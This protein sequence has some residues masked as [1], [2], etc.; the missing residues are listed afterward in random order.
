MSFAA[1]LTLNNWREQ[2]MPKLLADLTLNNWREQDMVELLSSLPLDLDTMRPLILRVMCQW[3]QMSAQ[4]L[5]QHGIDVKVIA[6]KQALVM[7]KLAPELFELIVRSHY[8]NWNLFAEWVHVAKMSA[9][10]VSTQIIPRHVPLDDEIIGHHGLTIVRTQN[11]RNVLSSPDWSAEN[12]NTIWA[13]LH[14]HV[15]PSQ[16]LE[17]QNVP[18]VLMAFDDL[19]YFDLS[20]WLRSPHP[21]QEMPLELLEPKYFNEWFYTVPDFFRFSGCSLEFC[22]KFAE[23]VGW[24]TDLCPD[25]VT[26]HLQNMCKYQY[27]SEDFVICFRHLNL[28][29]MASEYVSFSR[30]IL[31]FWKQLDLETLFDA[32]DGVN[33][34][35]IE[36]LYCPQDMMQNEKRNN[37]RVARYFAQHESPVWGVAKFDKVNFE[38][39]NVSRHP[40][41]ML[42]LKQI[43]AL[44]HLEMFNQYPTRVVAMNLQ[45]QAELLHQVVRLDLVCC[46]AL[47]PQI[48]AK[49]FPLIIEAARFGC[50]SDDVLRHLMLINKIDVEMMSNVIEQM[51][52]LPDL[53]QSFKSKSPVEQL[54][55]NMIRFQILPF[56]VVAELVPVVFAKS[57]IEGLIMT[58]RLQNVV[59]PATITTLGPSLIY[60][61]EFGWYSSQFVEM[62]FDIAGELLAARAARSWNVRPYT[63]S[64]AQL[65]VLYAD[66]QS[67]RDQMRRWHLGGAFEWPVDV[68]KFVPSLVRYFTPKEA[69][70]VV[71]GMVTSHKEV[72]KML[73]RCNCADGEYLYLV[74]KGAALCI[75]Q[76]W[77]D[78]SN[79]GQHFESND[80]NLAC[81]EL[82]MNN[83]F[84]PDFCF[85]NPNVINWLYFFRFSSHVSVDL[86]RAFANPNRG[87][88]D[89]LMQ[90]P[91]ICPQT[92]EEMRQ[93]WP[94]LRWPRLRLRT[95][96]SNYVWTW[97]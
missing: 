38:P 41:S 13:K 89:A 17:Y 55:D 68:E 78:Q 3:H 84:S 64:R 36:L 4:F 1:D 5:H 80:R 97:Q 27:L 7:S 48:V 53:R 85:S 43:S 74:K 62:C 66:K 23:L 35:L 77:G 16:I 71:D 61:L 10:F 79:F 67:S 52:Q 31:R 33:D 37:V 83:T 82:Y 25:L 2:D 96:L 20:D 65:G 81:A 70:Q 72:L 6:K 95:F 28:I 30:K 90:N 32:N 59:S 93:I 88:L 26:R 14:G 92:L 40:K 73:K 9:S 75:E 60:F 63:F 19:S 94:D 12:L 22:T 50:L 46:E 21:Y 58:S 54:V 24:R 69:R 45:E 11:L 44:N 8:I 42:R 51:L 57:G 18:N 29:Q 56:D 15:D 86:V 91:H 39:A 76:T 87:D 34:T 47:T 49:C